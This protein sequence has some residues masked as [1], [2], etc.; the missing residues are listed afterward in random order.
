MK[1]A[2][3]L[4][5]LIAIIGT[6][7]RQQTIPSKKMPIHS[8][9]TMKEKLVTKDKELLKPS[10]DLLKALKE[11]EYKSVM[12]HKTVNKILKSQKDSLSLIAN[13]N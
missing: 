5:V 8:M 13:K 2:I 3:S 12:C 11:V 7:A 9:D 4:F 1:F 6:S 10:E